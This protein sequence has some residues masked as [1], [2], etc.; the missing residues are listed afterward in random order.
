MP[1]TAPI[2]KW[3]VATVYVAAAG[4]HDVAAEQ[5]E[6]LEQPEADD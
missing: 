4:A 2:G 6:H 5:A 3:L 1:R